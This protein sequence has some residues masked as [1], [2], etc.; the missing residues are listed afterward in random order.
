[1]YVCDKISLIPE[2]KM[3]KGVK[4]AL[5]LS[6][7][8]FAPEKWCAKWQEIRKSIGEQEHGADNVDIF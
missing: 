5:P 3:P 6:G 7:V 1:M 4:R 8:G 2:R